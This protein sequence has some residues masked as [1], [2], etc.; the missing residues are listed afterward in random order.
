MAAESIIQSKQTTETVHGILTEVVCTVFS[1]YIFVVV[2][3]YGKMGTLISLVPHCVANDVSKPTFST[4]VLMGKD[5]P[6][7][8]V[9]AKHLVT[10]VSEESGNKPVLLALALKNAN[11]ETIKSIKKLIQ[12]C[13]LW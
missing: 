2:T 7:I 9:Y 11:V 1:D 12:S 13:R 5:E 6:L 3:Q 8:H 10:F 4:K